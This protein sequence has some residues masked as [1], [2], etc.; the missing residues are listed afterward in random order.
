MRLVF[1]HQDCAVQSSWTRALKFRGCGHERNPSKIYIPLTMGAHLET[2]WLVNVK[3]VPTE[4]ILFG[5][6]YL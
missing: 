5:C 1:H 4:T 6:Q 2:L 3:W